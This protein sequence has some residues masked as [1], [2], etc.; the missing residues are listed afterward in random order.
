MADGL[1]SYS[2]YETLSQAKATTGKIKE[3]LGTVSAKHEF[4]V[5]EGFTH[6]Y[7]N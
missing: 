3:V 5:V 7:F 6:Q 1:E 4:I 2:N